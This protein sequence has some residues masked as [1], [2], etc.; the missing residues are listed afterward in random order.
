MPCPCGVVWG[1][2]SREGRDPS[3]QD[4]G[5]EMTSL[6]VLGFWGVGLGAQVPG[7]RVQGF[8]VLGF[9]G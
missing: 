2:E 8:R 6:N 4:T 9:W 3:V 5:F 7:F 1:S